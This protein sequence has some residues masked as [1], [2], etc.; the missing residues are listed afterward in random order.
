M[1]NVRLAIKILVG[2]VGIIVF[3][4]LAMIFFVRTALNDTLYDKL[5]KRGVSITRHIAQVSVESVPCRTF[6][7]TRTYRAGLS[8]VRKRR[9][10]HLF[11]QLPGGSRRANL[12]QPFSAGL[13]QENRPAPGREL[14]TRRLESDQGPVLDIAVPL[15]RGS[16]GTAHLGFSEASV[17]KDVDEIVKTIVWDHRYRSCR[18]HRFCRGPFR[19][20]HPS[21]P[22]T[23]RSRASR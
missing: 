23:R 8:E 6:R 7:G 13:T 18:R 11:R 17:K 4:G 5:E 20:D 14:S 1:R 10:V 16:A 22:R 2:T 15:L 12:R 3:L 21:R 9:R 19:G